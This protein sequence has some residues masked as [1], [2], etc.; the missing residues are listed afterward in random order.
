MTN[1]LTGREMIVSCAISLSA[2][3]NASNDKLLTDS[4][5]VKV[6]N[7]EILHLIWSKMITINNGVVTINKGS[8]V[9]VCKS[10][11][12]YRIIYQH[13]TYQQNHGII[14]LLQCKLHG[15]RLTEINQRSVTIKYTK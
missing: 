11:E 4:R 10:G 13:D 8:T 12:K 2:K 6:R 5:F 7:N 1:I 3:G 9:I 15:S 14:Q